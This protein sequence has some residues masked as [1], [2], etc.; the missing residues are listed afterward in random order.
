MQLDIIPGKRSSELFLNTKVGLAYGA[1]PPKVA[2]TIKCPLEEAEGIFTA[3]HTEMYPGITEYR[4]QYVLPTA[5]ENGEIHLG[6]GFYLKTDF[7]DN[8]IRT[9]HNATAQFWS[10]LT[11]LTINKMHHLIDEAGYEEDILITSTI[12]D[13]IYAEITEDPC[14]IK[15]YN[16]NIVPVMEKDFVVDQ[17]VKNEARVEIGPSWADLTELSENASIEEIQEVLDSYSEQG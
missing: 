15:W 9:L 4:E 1:Y 3:Y 8:D 10:I 13:S 12:Y 7:P 5:I 6:L 11:A 14:I 17:I 2:R 16:D